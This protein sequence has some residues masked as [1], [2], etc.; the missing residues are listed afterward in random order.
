MVDRDG[1]SGVDAVERC[2]V[3][4]RQRQYISRQR[5]WQWCRCSGADESGGVG[6]SGSV[7][8]DGG[9]GVDAVELS[10]LA[11][12]AAVDRPLEMVAVVSR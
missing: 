6:G 10:S 4:W 2:R 12:A 8:R 5:W 11:M 3:W 1:G 7:D 9:S